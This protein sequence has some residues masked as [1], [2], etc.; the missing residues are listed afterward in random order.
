MGV[1]LGFMGVQL[2]G[3]IIWAGF[4]GC[5]RGT[6]TAGQQPEPVAI[7]L[8]GKPHHVTASTASGLRLHPGSPSLQFPQ[9]KHS[10]RSDG[11]YCRIYFA[12]EMALGGPLL[13]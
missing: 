13:C 6:G 5:D 2:S 4:P 7:F 1:Q 11:W 10:V 3:K 9:A 8:M 12:C